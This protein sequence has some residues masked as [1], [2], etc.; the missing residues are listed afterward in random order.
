MPAL[1]KKNTVNIRVVDFSAVFM[2]LNLTSY[3]FNYLSIN[4]L[5]FLALCLASY[6]CEVPE[7]N[8]DKEK[9]KQLK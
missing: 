9:H 6:E 2:T 1:P 8:Y 5:S 3:P 4:Y 7:T